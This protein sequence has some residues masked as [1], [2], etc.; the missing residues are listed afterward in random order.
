MNLIFS[1]VSKLVVMF[2]KEEA[3]HKHY[4]THHLTRYVI[5]LLKTSV[6][7]LIRWH[8]LILYSPAI[9]LTSIRSGEKKILTLLLKLKKVIFLQTVSVVGGDSHRKF[10]LLL[11]KY[12]K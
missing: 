5:E 1:N 9:M 2:L 11:S 6:K 8:N 4:F 7:H 12:I 3:W 10:V